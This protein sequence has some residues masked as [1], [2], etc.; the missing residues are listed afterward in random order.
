MSKIVAIFPG[1]GTQFVGMGKSFYDDYEVARRTYDEANEILGYNLADICFNGS[2]SKLNNNVVLFPA[3]ITTSVSIYRCFIEKYHIRPSYFM[4]NSLGEYSAMVCAGIIRFFDALKIV[5][6]R[7]QIADECNKNYTMT[8]IDH[9]S[10][11][12]VIEQICESMQIKGK[13]VYVSCYNTKSQIVV[14]GKNEDIMDVEEKLMELGAQITPLMTAGPFH[15]PCMNKY[16][17]EF[18]A[19]LENTEIYEGEYDLISNV[20]GRRIGYVTKTQ[21][22][23]LMVDHLIHPVRWQESL[24]NVTAYEDVMFIEMNAKKYLKNMLMEIVSHDKAYSYGVKQDRD[25]MEELEAFC[26]EQKYTNN[27]LEEVNVVAFSMLP[28]NNTQLDK[29]KII[30]LRN[31]LYEIDNQ[32]KDDKQK[33]YDMLNVLEQI[34]LEK[35]IEA[36]ERKYWKQQIKLMFNLC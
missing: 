9:V 22:I 25:K 10:N 36:K 6:Y 31:I 32:D 8:I 11:K 5:Q 27:L 14:S 20:T 24:E 19:L 4:G 1:Q 21:M 17:S 35:Q 18:R 2:I 16:C 12:T 30:N 15:S 28:N 26:C 34:M 29:K 7:G 3:I 33:G 13:E 23:N